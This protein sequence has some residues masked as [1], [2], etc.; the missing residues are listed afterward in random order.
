MPETNW[1]LPPGR[2]KRL[3]VDYCNGRDGVLPPQEQAAAPCRTAYLS[4]A[5]AGKARVSPVPPFLAYID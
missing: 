3:R 2:A 1:G 5:T 4:L